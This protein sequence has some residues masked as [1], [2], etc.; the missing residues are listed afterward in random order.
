MFIG[1]QKGRE[2]GKGCFDSVKLTLCF[3][4]SS[5]EGDKIVHQRDQRF[6]LFSSDSSL[7]IRCA[8]PLISRRRIEVMSDTSRIS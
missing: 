2:G 8:W 6:A 4:Y 7:T 3:E 1:K 5:A